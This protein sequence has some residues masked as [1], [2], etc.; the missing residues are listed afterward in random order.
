MQPADHF[1]RPVILV[2]DLVKYLSDLSKLWAPSSKQPPGGLRIGQYC[3]EWLV[4]FV[5]D[6]SREF[7]ENG[8]PHQMRDF[9]P[10]TFSLGLG[11]LLIGDIGKNSRDSG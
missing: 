1:A 6:R 11:S 3:S 4:Q 5:S 2:H 7:T 10:L 8:N 9:L